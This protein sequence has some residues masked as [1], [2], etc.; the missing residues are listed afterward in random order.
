[1]APVDAGAASDA[2]FDRCFNR[3]AEKSGAA[4][5]GIKVE[6][7]NRAG[8]VN[9]SS[10]EDAVAA[11]IDKLALAVL[12]SPVADNS[13][14][15]PLEQA[16]ALAAKNGVESKGAL[17]SRFARDPQGGKH[18]D[19]RMC[20]TWKAPPNT[21]PVFAGPISW[22]LSHKKSNQEKARNTKWKLSWEN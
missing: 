5:H 13:K 14:D 16:F 9:D 1:M 4:A 18:P 10:E 2:L 19:Y 6:R 15:D 21:N 7:S 20:K 3:L 12:R 17:G 22:F 8:S 11:E